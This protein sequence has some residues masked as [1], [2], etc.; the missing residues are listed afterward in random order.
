V[1]RITGCHAVL[2]HVEDGVASVTLNR[3]QVIDAVSADMVR[4]ITDAVLAA[5]R[6]PLTCHMIP[7]VKETAS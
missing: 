4:I 7:L 1:T 2:T 5:S 6:P 3:P